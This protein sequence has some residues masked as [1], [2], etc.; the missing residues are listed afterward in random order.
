[1]YHG[2]EEDGLN[3]AGFDVIQELAPQLF[4]TTA[5]GYMLRSLEVSRMHASTVRKRCPQQSSACGIPMHNG[6]ELQFV[7]VRYDIR[8]SLDEME[9]PDLLP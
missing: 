6:G 3:V 1:M 8:S 5:T 7:Q 4:W 9:T 2:R